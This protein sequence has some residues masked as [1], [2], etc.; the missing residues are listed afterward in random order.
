M[1]SVK[2]ADQRRRP[3]CGTPQVTISNDVLRTEPAAG[4]AAGTAPLTRSGFRRDAWN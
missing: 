2:P 1:T 3:N 4:R